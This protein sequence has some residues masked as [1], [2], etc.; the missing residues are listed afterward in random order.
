MH[1]ISVDEALQ[2]LTELLLELSKPPDYMGSA[3]TLL[4]RI[5]HRIRLFKGEEYAALCSALGRWLQGND[6][7]KAD[8]A[9]ALISRLEIVRYIS[10]LEQWLDELHRGSF[11]WPSVWWLPVVED[12]LAR[13]HRAKQRT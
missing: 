13:L 2:F 9:L 8:I 3:E 12:T 5:E 11:H 6:P 1:S 4:D 7:A 10:E